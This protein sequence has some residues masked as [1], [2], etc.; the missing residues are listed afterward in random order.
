MSKK[1][2]F[3]TGASGNMGQEGLR[4]LLERRERF[5][6]VV[7]VL[8]TAK[9]RKIMAAYEGQPGLK[10]VWGDLT[11]YEDVLGCV[12]GA[13]IVLHVGGLVSPAADR[14]PA[15]T[16][17]VNIGSVQNIIRAIKAQPEPDQ[18]KLV[19]I[20][21][22][23][24]TG[25]RNQP[26]H[27]GRVGDPIQISVYDNYALSKTIAER[28]VI[29]SGLRHWVSLRQTGIAHWALMDTMS[30]QDAAITFHQP[31]N[32]V[33]EWVTVRDAGRLLANACEDGVPEEFWNDIYNIGGGESCR[34]VNHQFMSKVGLLA[35][36]KDFRAMFEA[37]WFA[38]RNFHG[39]WYE[40]SQRL[41]DFLQFRRESIDDYIAG[42]RARLPLW[43]R[44][45][46][47]CLPASV[48]K[49]AMRRVAEGPGGPLYW[50][51]HND[52]D[53]IAAYFGSKAEWEAI[54]AWD[55]YEL[56]YP[57]KTP[58]R[59]NHGYDES[60]PREA[61]G[62][63][64]MRQA[65]AFRGGECLS[66]EVAGFFEK[67]DWRCAFNHEFQASP[68][69]VL[70]AGHWCP[71]CLTPPWRDGD[72]AARNPFFA[73]VWHAHHDQAERRVYRFKAE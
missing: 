22:I 62:I 41:E 73:Q 49:A 1:T 19:Y 3:L 27:W 53:H 44:L 63:A 18:A 24:Q 70:R 65:A 32:G 58:V 21:T 61:L 57:S 14:M 46:M 60:K 26:V 9:D 56:Q 4:Q 28:E 43:R 52:A 54:P 16:T 34:V 37:N 51:A 25:D 31:V 48:M 55:K 6:I 69:L 59:L 11:R 40:D 67:L 68:M 45:L 29:E 20:G 17:K 72:V 33:F 15:L 13:D 42:M 64:D 7:L 8:P 23:A 12:T 10:I 5:D 38:T 36:V 71:D 47:K 30:G 50:M 35:G 66:T 39:Q 2:I